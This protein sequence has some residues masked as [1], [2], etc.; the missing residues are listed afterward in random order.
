MPLH[1]VC[2]RLRGH[3]SIYNANTSGT[4]LCGT[5]GTQCC[6]QHHLT[7][8]PS[9]CAVPKPNSLTTLPY[10]AHPVKRTTSCCAGH[11]FASGASQ[12][13]HHGEPTACP[14]PLPAPPLPPPNTPLRNP[15]WKY[16]LSLRGRLTG[17]AEMRASSSWPSTTRPTMRLVESS[18]GLGIWVQRAPWGPGQGACH[19]LSPKGTGK[20]RSMIPMNIWPC[21]V[22][23]RQ[24]RSLDTAG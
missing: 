24:A 1:C 9:K 13:R 17:S 18:S 2:M 22:V 20:H 12:T 21:G 15:T 7:K 5:A 3:S 11:S 10:V 16:G 23:L 19:D 6:V 14:E 8:R 4:G